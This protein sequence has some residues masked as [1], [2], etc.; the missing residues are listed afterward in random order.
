MSK[1]AGRVYQRERTLCPP[2]S[3]EADDLL[4]ERWIKDLQRL[5][6][7]RDVYVEVIA[8]WNA[9]VQYRGGADPL[10]PKAF[11]DYVLAVYQEIAEVEREIGP[12]GMAALETSWA[13]MERRNESDSTGELVGSRAEE[14]GWISHLRRL[15]EVI[16][17][18][19]PGLPPQPFQPLV[20]EPTG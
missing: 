17:R 16:D 11:C 18:F 19:F 3:W 14:P 12:E 20:V 10:P 1:L 9:A 8:R 4:P 6:Y 2:G 5:R 15:R 7:R 13:S